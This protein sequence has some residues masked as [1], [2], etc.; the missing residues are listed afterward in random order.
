MST[1]L[2]SGI[3]S[4]PA[5]ID[6]LRSIAFGSITGSYQL[7]GTVFAHANYL[8][9]VTNLTDAHML[10][11]TNGIDDKDIVPANGFCLYDLSGDSLL[12][13]IGRGVY[14]KYVSAPTSGSLYVTAIF[15]GGN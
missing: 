5:A 4:G 14:V 1:G 8:I 12:L 13:P 10:L 3:S 2:T 7:I 9:K 15:L 6:N 11:S